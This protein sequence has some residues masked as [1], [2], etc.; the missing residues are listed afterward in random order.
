MGPEGVG[1]IESVLMLFVWSM[2]RR[3]EIEIDWVGWF[4]IRVLRSLSE[5]CV[6]SFGGTYL[7]IY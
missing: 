6:G 4:Q 1:V 7:G 5:G 3:V 2:D